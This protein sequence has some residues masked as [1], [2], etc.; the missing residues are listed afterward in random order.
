MTECVNKR[1]DK[2]IKNLNSS[3]SNII[4]DACI[5]AINLYIK[6]VYG[7]DDEYELA[8]NTYYDIIL[9]IDYD[10]LFKKMVMMTFRHKRAVLI[11][12]EFGS[13]Y[14]DG[15][16]RTIVGKGG[17]LLGYVYSREFVLLIKDAFGSERWGFKYYSDLLIKGL[18]S[19]SAIKDNFVCDR[20]VFGAG[21]GGVILRKDLFSSEG[22]VRIDKYEENKIDQIIEGFISDV[23]SKNIC[24][25]EKDNILKKKFF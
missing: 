13:M 17:E 21:K 3:I 22:L 18:N 15:L 14:G 4:T 23:N 10:D 12:L 9:G 16:S 25:I 24:R 6:I 11:R 5:S 1:C 19:I 20:S 2:H 8:D 7:G